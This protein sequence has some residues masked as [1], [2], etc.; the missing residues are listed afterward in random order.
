MGRL[1]SQL[2][3]IWDPSQAWLVLISSLFKWLAA[4]GLRVVEWL[5]RVQL[6]LPLQTRATGTV[7][8]VVVIEWL[9]LL[10]I[11]GAAAAAAAATERRFAYAIK[12]SIMY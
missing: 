3:S 12:V 4:S 7:V 1:S 6:A 2:S 10:A 8:G 5:S 11:I 9:V